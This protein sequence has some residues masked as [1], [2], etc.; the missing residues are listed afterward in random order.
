MEGEKMKIEDKLFNVMGSFIAMN[1]YIDKHVKP[2]E[3]MLKSRS[4]NYGLIRT[5]MI[6]SEFITTTGMDKR[7]REYEKKVNDKVAKK[8]EKMEK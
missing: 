7:Y 6:A 4:A 5:A 8:I 2:T 3:H 1:E